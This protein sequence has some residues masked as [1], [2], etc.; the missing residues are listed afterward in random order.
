MLIVLTPVAVAHAQTGPKSIAL[1]HNSNVPTANILKSFQKR[2]PNVAV[3]SDAIKSDYTLEAIKTVTRPGLKLERVDNFD[4]TLLD[5]DGTIVR[6]AST[7]SLTDGMKDLCRAVEKSIPFEV[8]DTNNLTLSSDVRGDTSH[9]LGGALATSLTGRR[10]HTDAMT[11]YA[12]VKGE[13]ALLDCYEHRTG[14]ATIA[15]GK[16]YGELEGNSIWVD[17]RMPVT[18]KPV[19]NHYKIA[20]SW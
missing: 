17:Y 18:H 13:H 14:C 2:C 8:V 16:Y 11:M 20:G 3:V 9:G 7:G 4:L 15:P 1:T 19:R 5:R 12:I 6:S 10:T